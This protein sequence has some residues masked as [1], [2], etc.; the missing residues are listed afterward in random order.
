MSNNVERFAIIS[1]I[2]YHLF[3]CV[4]YIREKNDTFYLS[5]F[6]FVSF[7]FVLFRFVLFCFDFLGRIGVISLYESIK[8]THV[9][10]IQRY[11]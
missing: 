7:Y 3:L 5:L 8:A 11:Q 10:S 4:F 6:H 2:L 9:Y 1:Y